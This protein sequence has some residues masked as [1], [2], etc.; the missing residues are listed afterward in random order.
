MLSPRQQQE[1]EGEGVREVARA[2]WNVFAGVKKVQGILDLDVYI[3]VV[4]V[5]VYG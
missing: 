1:T 5:C 2:S 4:R 3:P